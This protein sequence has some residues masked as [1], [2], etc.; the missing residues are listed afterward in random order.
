MGQTLQSPDPS[1]QQLLLA[2]GAVHHRLNLS[3]LAMQEQ[4]SPSGVSKMIRDLEGKLGADLFVRQGKKLAGVTAVGQQ[5][6]PIIERIATELDNLSGLPRA[7]P[8]RVRA[9][10]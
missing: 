6:L 2:R 8:L 7:L 9:G 5:A 1:L 10:W 3:A 4:V